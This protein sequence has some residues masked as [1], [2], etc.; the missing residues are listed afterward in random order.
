MWITSTF[1]STFVALAI[2]LMLAADVAF[3]SATWTPPGDTITRITGTG[4]TGF[5]VEHYDGTV[6]HPPTTSEAIAEC[7]EYDTLLERVRCRV[8]VRT[9]YDALGD[10]R[11]ALRYARSRGS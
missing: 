6:T 9:R 11:Q 2:G 4:S 8:Q 1:G 7:G 5:A 10:T 3:A